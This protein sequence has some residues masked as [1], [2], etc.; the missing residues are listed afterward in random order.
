MAGIAFDFREAAR[1]LRRHLSVTVLSLTC[2]ALGVGTSAAMLGLLDALLFRPPAHVVAP[3][4]VK[5]LY[6][7]DRLAGLGEYTSSA[8]SYPVVQDL[9][10]V[11]SFSVVGSFFSTEIPVGRG[12]E[13]QKVSG[14]L[15]SPSFLRLLGVRPLRGRMFTETESRPDQPAAVAILGYDFWRRG[16]GGADDAVGRQ[17]VIHG[18]AY[19]LIG[20]L[21][22]RFT[23]VDLESVD[24]W[25]PMSAAGSLVSKKWATSR[26]TQ[27]LETVARL[28]P[29]VAETA[30]AQEATTVFRASAAEA[31]RPKPA[32]RV[33]L[34]PIQ[35][36]QGPDAPSSLRVVIFL[37]ALSWAVLL[38]GCAN[39]ASLLLLRGLDR[40]REW[41]LRAALGAGRGRIARLVLCE[42]II[43]SWMGGLAA[44][45]VCVP[46]GALL[47][48][49]ILPEAGALIQSTDLRR[50]GFVA[51]LALAAGLI[52]GL[53]PALWAARRDLTSAI[54]SGTRERA[55]GR[56]RWSL[57]ISAAQIALTLTLL[58]GAGELARSL[59]NVLHL[60]LGIDAGRVLVATVDLKD[61]GYPQA[62]I[63]E[64]YRQAEERVRRLPGVVRVSLAATIPFESSK[65]GALSVPGVPQLPDLETGG[66][67]INAVSPGFFAT[68]GTRLVRGRDF[69][70][71]DLSGATPVAIVS[72]TMAGLLWGTGEPLGKCLRIGGEKAPC[73][74]VVGV[75]EDARRAELQEGPTLQYYVPIAQAPPML[76]SRALFVRTARNAE[77]VQGLVRREVQSLAPDLPFVE[78]RSLADLLAPQLQPWKMGA[79]VLAFFGL[80]ALMLALVGLY[81]VIAHT[82]KKR[83]FELGVRIAHGAQRR[84]ILR[85]VLRQGLGIGIVGSAAGVLLALGIARFLQPLLFQVSARDP[86]ILG[87]TSALVLLLAILASW[88]SSQ[89]VR[90]VDPA[91]V[92]RGE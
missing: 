35:R 46:I 27:F 29:D 19:T 24:L 73:S 58:A 54:R 87:S 15:A 85:L 16:F 83:T 74:Q 37:T 89:R 13:A 45:A 33:S 71:Q 44:V 49:M 18:Q 10:R 41:G 26:G 47:Q 82:L 43:L 70:P 81:G 63:D 75:A 7:T 6:L 38:I 40:Q 34:G 39:V 11:K 59:Y 52:S 84:D 55:P 65:A 60:H 72:R 77:E 61:E 91:V 92:L 1:G 5:R 67:Y 21:P 23:G 62:R 20:V 50:L 2:L 42:G 3:G 64:I 25:L 66:P 8:T 14:V 51:V 53:V 31:G 32:A 69:S 17:V 9:A 90:H 80:V 22:S 79:G 86:L 48:R 57:A 36:A 28:R 78:V 76:S 12:V 88:I 4:S 30:A 68:T 56:S